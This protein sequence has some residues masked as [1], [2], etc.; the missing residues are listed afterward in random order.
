[1]NI[2]PLSNN[3]F[4]IPEVVEAKTASGI[5]LPDNK[6]EQPMTGKVVA[7]GGSV[8]GV[9]VGDQV[10]Y[11]RYSLTEVEV[12]HI[13]YLVGPEQDILAILQ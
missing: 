8:A 3:V 1:M 12:D 7:V 11:K 6:E 4:I 5:L 13:K 9:K 10:L 2:K